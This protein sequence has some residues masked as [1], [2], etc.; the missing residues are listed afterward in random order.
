MLTFYNPGEIDPRSAQ[1]FGL[2]VKEGP[3]S[4]GHFGTGL[5]YGIAI[6]LRLGGTVTIYSG[7]TKYEFATSPTRIRGKEFS[8]VTM[9]GAGQEVTL[10]FTLELGK[11]WQPWQAYREFWANAKDEQG[12]VGAGQAPPK[13][14][15]TYI[16]VNSPELDL[17]H[18]RRREFIL[19]SKPIHIH[20]LG[21]G[22]GGPGVIEIHRNPEGQKSE[23][24][25]YQG[26]KV[27]TTD[28]PGLYTYNL[29]ASVALTEDRS[30][31]NWWAVRR[32]IIS[33][34]ISAPQEL[35]SPALLSGDGKWE[36]NADWSTYYTPPKSFMDCVNRLA[37]H[38]RHR[39][40]PTLVA[41]VLPA[42]MPSAVRL[43]RVE[44]TM[45]DR[46]QAFLR[47]VLKTPISA[48]IR[49]VESLG[50]LILGSVHDQDGVK[51]ILLTKE[52]FRQGT[53]IIAGTLLEEHIHLT[54][55]LRDTSRELQNHLLNL[56]ISMGEENQG[57]PL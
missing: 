43:T 40:P 29:T 8:L 39:L 31:A 45:L 48:P 50:D 7:L 28:K 14:G 13:A 21:A 27:F 44:Q 51:T 25:Y 35:L 26:L 16:I 34:L 2:N 33:A 54:L 38:H 19:E 52:A 46:A 17:A 11:D 55:G 30:L 47:N 56:L 24:I 18:T 20:D 12:R 1:I 41:D 15:W 9:R 42:I 5:K 22:M 32:Q 4:I 6:V 3:S 37:Q 57:S 23:S 36:W 53:K 49:V 10:P